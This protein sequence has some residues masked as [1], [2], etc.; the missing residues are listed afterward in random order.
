MCL[1]YN[2]QIIAVDSWFV[3]GAD[4]LTHKLPASPDVGDLGSIDSSLSSLTRRF[5]QVKKLINYYS[6]HSY[7]KWI[8][9]LSS[10]EIKWIDLLFRVKS[11]MLAIHCTITVCCKMRFYGVDVFPH[12]F[13]N[14][15]GRNIISNVTYITGCNSYAMLRR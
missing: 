9:T 13:I 12:I 7:I 11:V 6:C 15:A 4:T 3:G 5:F 8:H 14:D 1:R 10:L 2:G